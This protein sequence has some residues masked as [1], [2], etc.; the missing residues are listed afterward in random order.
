MLETPIRIKRKEINLIPMINIIFL[1]LTFFILAGTIEKIDPFSLNLPTATKRGDIKP[2]RISIIYI[3][4]DGR[5]AVNDDLV[6]R[7]DLRTIINTILIEN[8]GQE[9]LI[10]SDSDV[11]SADLIWVMRAIEAVGGSDVSIVTKVIK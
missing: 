1:L 5:I 9:I 11:G 3:H 6:S 10:K 2:Q 4:K 7:K 8:K